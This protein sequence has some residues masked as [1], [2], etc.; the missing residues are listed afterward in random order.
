MASSRA[1]QA[2]RRRTRGSGWFLY[3]FQPASVVRTIRTMLGPLTLEIA[4]EGPHHEL[5]FHAGG[6]VRMAIVED[7]LAVDVAQVDTRSRPSSA[8]WPSARRAAA[9]RGSACRA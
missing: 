9:C 4:V 3:R 7:R 8:P 2:K 1:S 6:N 5:A